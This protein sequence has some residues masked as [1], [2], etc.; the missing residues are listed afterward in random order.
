MMALNVLSKFNFSTNTSYR[1]VNPNIG[2][3]FEP[4]VSEEVTQYHDLIFYH[5]ATT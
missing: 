5:Q 3:M 1:F 2:G 4:K